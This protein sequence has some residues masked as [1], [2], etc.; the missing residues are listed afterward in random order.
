MFGF[1]EQY[2]TVYVV[3]LGG[4][5][6]ILV[7]SAALVLLK[8]G[9]VRRIAAITLLLALTRLALFYN[10]YAWRFY[11]TS[12]DKVDVGQRQA[13]VLRFER[14][15]LL[16][17]RDVQLLALGSSQTD[18]VY[19][20]S[21]S[22][23]TDLAVLTLSGMG[24]VDFLLYKDYIL[25]CKPEALLLYLSEFDVARPPK[26]TAVKLAPN[27]GFNW[28][29]ILPLLRSYTDFDAGEVREA[30]LGNLLLE[31]KYAW[32]FK[33]LREK[34]FQS[35]SGFD[36]HA[37]T[38]AGEDRTAVQLARLE[39]L[40]GA[41][42]DTNLKVVRHFVDSMVDHGIPVFIVEGQY[43]PKAY[44][45]K[46]IQL[47]A[48]VAADLE[49]MAADRDDLYFIARQEVGELP[50]SAYRDG[51]HVRKERAYAY[52]DRIL[53]IV[54]ELKERARETQ[55]TKS[56][57][58]EPIGEPRPIAQGPGVVS[59]AL[60]HGNP[61]DSPFPRQ[62]RSGNVSDRQ[63]HSGDPGQDLIPPENAVPPR[64]ED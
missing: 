27:Q 43:N 22:R 35:W 5:V 60:A 17:C 51:Y 55:N 23:R 28:F 9:V 20:H 59:A 44:S 7:F 47:N 19:S 4:F 40:D 61:M 8:R 32:V 13:N 29:E 30:L 34:W 58:T 64:S 46:N 42:I 3:E 16:N 24:P 62:P 38:P 50:E 11:S 37:K 45:P 53:S 25:R 39:R 63:S 2:S 31:Y 10:P 12:L 41:P 14:K 56:A 36:N 33:S 52:A 18:A 6:A 48:R 26:W 57:R 54:V 49:K 15:R 1:L 21:A